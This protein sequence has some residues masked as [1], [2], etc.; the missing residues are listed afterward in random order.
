MRKVPPPALPS[1][2][3]KRTGLRLKTINLPSPA[4]LQE[5]CGLWQQGG[6]RKSLYL[7][8]EMGKGKRGRR[9]GWGDQGRTGSLLTLPLQ[10][11][12]FGGP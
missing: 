3:A 6:D 7:L 10:E 12:R 8:T 4:R 1:T 2:L 9:G 5:R 11:V